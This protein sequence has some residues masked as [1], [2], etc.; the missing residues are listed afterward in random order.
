MLSRFYP[1]GPVDFGSRLHPLPEDGSVPGM[2][3]WRWF[4]TPGHSVG[5][6]SFWREADRALIAGDAFVTTAQESAYAF[7]LQKPEMHG[8]PKYCTVDWPTAGRSVAALAALQPDLV[9]TGHGQ[10]MRGPEM[11]AALDRLAREFRSVAVPRHGRYLDQPARVE[12]GSAYC[13]PAA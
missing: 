6:V 4:H 7:V 1:R 5:Q 11:S 10:P 2:P 9:I 12:D 8:P 3:G 13:R